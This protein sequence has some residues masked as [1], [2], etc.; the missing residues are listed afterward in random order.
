MSVPSNISGLKF[1]LRNDSDAD[2]VKQI[3]QDD[4]YKID[5]F[6]PPGGVVVDIG[7]HIGSFSIKCAKIKKC[8][9]FA[10]EPLTGTFELMKQNVAL[11][12]V[13]GRIRL[14]NTA[15][16]GSPDK[17]RLMYIDCKHFEESGFISAR[18]N[19]AK[20]FCMSLAEVFKKNRIS[21]C[22]VLKLDC[23]GAEFEI[24]R[25]IEFDRVKKIIM[26]THFNLHKVLIEFLL[27]KGFWLRVKSIK[28]WRKLIFAK[29]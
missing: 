14:Y 15:I 8:K 9:V 28:P 16:V 2:V 19:S 1:V 12:R 20:V 4:I 24:L 29:R 6:V 18:S 5:K 21:L 27:E 23:E 25:E 17:T 13:K 22:D 10:F 3:V 7:A 11:N 26:E